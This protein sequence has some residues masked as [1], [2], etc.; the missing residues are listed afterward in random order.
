[1]PISDR[2]WE[3]IKVSIEAMHIVNLAGYG[4]MVSKDNVLAILSRWREEKPQKSEPPQTDKQ[5]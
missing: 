5:E 3:Q 1:M 2:E 4:H